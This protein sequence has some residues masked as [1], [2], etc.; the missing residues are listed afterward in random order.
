MLRLALI[1]VL[2]TSYRA[3]AATGWKKIPASVYIQSRRMLNFGSLFGSATQASPYDRIT[4]QPVFAITTPWGSPYMNMEKLSDLDE[5]V[6]TDSSSKTPQSIS[7][8]QNEYRTVALY[9]MDPDDALAVHGE[10]KQIEQMAKTDIRVT[11][12]SLAKAVRQAS[13]L[14]N[15]LVTGAPPDPND[16]NLKLDQGGAL[17][18]KIVPP[19]RQLYYAARCIGK[20]RVGLFGETAQDDAQMAVLG[21]S[22]LEGMNLARRREKRERKTP[23]A[24]TAMQAAAAHMEGYSGIP[25]F[26]APDMRRRLP[27]LKRLISGTAQE[28]PLFFNY[29]D[30]EVA[31]KTMHQRSGGK[32]KGGGVVPEKPTNV[33][34]FNLWDVLTSMD[35][36]DWKQRQQKHQWVKA[37][38]GSIKDR[39]STQGP[40]GLNSITFVPSSRSAQYKEAISARGNGKARLRPMR[41][42]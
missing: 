20:E 6:Q 30:M 17:R 21:N 19:K 15:G 31:W 39:F 32:R 26:Y 27:L 28:S 22:A 12:M 23:K 29:E 1:A 38:L 42:R 11:S 33:E 40:P 41:G 5:V 37:P 10:M 25:V 13:N 14:G 3:E 35:R 18:Y 4:G 34:V 7:E 8:E 16:G 9:F 36:D 24:R 2:A